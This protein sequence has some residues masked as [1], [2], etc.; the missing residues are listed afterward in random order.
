MGV[1]PTIATAAVLRQTGW[2]LVLR[3]QQRNGG[4]LP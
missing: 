1:R 2:K 3:V 4:V